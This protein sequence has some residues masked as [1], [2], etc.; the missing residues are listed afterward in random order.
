M[1][2]KEI[3]WSA[4]HLKH[5]ILK[6]RLKIESLPSADSEKLTFGSSDKINQQANGTSLLPKS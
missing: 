6:C 1:M 4:N 2:A 3:F 5:C